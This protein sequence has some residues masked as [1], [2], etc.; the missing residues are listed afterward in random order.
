MLLLPLAIPAIAA[1]IGSTY[2][3]LVLAACR[4]EAPAA[5][6]PVGGP[7][8][9]CEGYGGTKVRVVEGDLRYMVSYGRDAADEPAAFETLPA[10]NHIGETIEWRLEGKRPFATI[11]RYFTDAE[12]GP[13]GQV[14]VVTKLGGKGQVCHVGYVDAL[15]NK[16]A[17]TVARQVADTMAAGFVCGKDQAQYFGV[18]AGQ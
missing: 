16:D 4:S 3:K 15:A 1:T 9:W 7:T 13:D 10:F 2:T 12:T 8:W 5:D 17:N 11:I 14:L 6:D 18:T